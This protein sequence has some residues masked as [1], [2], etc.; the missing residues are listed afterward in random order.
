MKDLVTKISAHG[1]I[2]LDEFA[3]GMLE[4]R[5]TPREN[6]KSPEEMVFGHPLWSVLP[7]ARSIFKRAHAHAEFFKRRTAQLKM[8]CAA[9]RLQ[10]LSG[11]PLIFPLKLA[12]AT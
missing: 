9:L 3:R 8:R 7:R 10:N 5:N 6:V 11:A 12:S 1:D 2:T 4:F